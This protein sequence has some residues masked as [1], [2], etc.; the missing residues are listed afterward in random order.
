MKRLYQLFDFFKKN[1]ITVMTGEWQYPEAAEWYYVPGENLKQYNLT[2]DDPRYA[3][4]AADFIEHMVKDK[5]Y[6]CIE[7]YDLGNEVNINPGSYQYDKWKQDKFK[8]L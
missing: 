2:L 5:N 6:T 1:N 3:Q 8:S 7:Q 4:I